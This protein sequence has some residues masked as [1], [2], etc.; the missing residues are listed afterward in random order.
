MCTLLQI[1]MCYQR[2][3]PIWFTWGHHIYFIFIWSNAAGWALPLHVS[4]CGGCQCVACVSMGRVSVSGVCQYVACVSMWRLSVCAVC[5]YVWH[6]AV[7]NECQFVTC[8]S[9]WRVSVCAV[10][11]CGVWGN[12]L[13]DATRLQVTASGQ[14]SV[15]FK[16][17]FKG[18]R[19]YFSIAIIRLRLDYKSL[20]SVMGALATMGTPASVNYKS[21]WVYFT[22]NILGQYRQATPYCSVDVTMVNLYFVL[23]PNKILWRHIHNV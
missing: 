4:V 16:W 21:I 23:K 17:K 6:V 5:Q 2:G 22:T 10:S 8:V 12:M 15:F 20:K 14:F 19:P 1:S 3:V 18:G 9:M 13:R 7:C 11:V